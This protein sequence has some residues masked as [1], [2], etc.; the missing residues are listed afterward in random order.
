MPDAFFSEIFDC[1]Y[2]RLDIEIAHLEEYGNLPLI[3]RDPFDRLLVAQARAEDL[4]LIGS[5]VLIA[6]YPV[7]TLW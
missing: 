3:H 4:V 2:E 1:G 5:D 6:K 7:R